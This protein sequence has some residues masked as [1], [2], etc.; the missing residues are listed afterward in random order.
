MLQSCGFSV[1]MG[2]APPEV[3]AAADFVAPPVSED[4]LAVA[5]FE[6]VLPRI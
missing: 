3:K 5:I 1:A 4:G 2:N 6:Y